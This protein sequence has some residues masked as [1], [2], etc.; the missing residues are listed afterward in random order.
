MV[1]SSTFTI[2]L[3]PVNDAPTFI[4]GSDQTTVSLL[5]AQTIL[6][7]ATGI[8]SGPA[9]EALQNIT[10][11]VTNDSPG[12]FLQQPAIAPN[13]R[14]TYTPTLLALGS[15]TVTVHVVDNGGTANGGIDTSAQQ[16]FTITI[17]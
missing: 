9:D 2:T 10:F 5:G 1:P 3:D 15:V 6:G 12:L 7:W 16:T 13:G 8:T 11:I 4:A 14:L 17:V